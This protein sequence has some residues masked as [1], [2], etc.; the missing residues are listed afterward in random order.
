MRGAFGFA[1]GRTTP[2][3]TTWWFAPVGGFLAA[4]LLWLAGVPVTFS[5]FLP[6]ALLR[7]GF[8]VLI[9]V[10]VAYLAMFLFWLAVYP[11]HL[12]FASQ[13]GVRM[14]LRQRLGAQMPAFVLMGVIIFVLVIFTSV[15]SAW[16]T[17]RMVTNGKAITAENAN[18]ATAP[19]QPS[20][21]LLPPKERY[22]FKFDPTKGMYFDIQRDG[23]PLPEGH[24]ANPTF[25]LHNSSAVAAADVTVTWQAE[26][27]EYRKLV[28]TG[29]LAKYEV[30]FRDDF[31]LDLV[32]SAGHPVPNFRYFPNPNSEAKFSFV[33]RDTDLF[34]PTGIYPIL[35]LFIAAKMPEE[36]GARTE[37]FPITIKA[38]WN[39]PDGGEPK[40]FRI[41]IRGVNTKPSGLGEAP[42]VAGYLEF[43]IE[44]SPG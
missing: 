37:A 41:K 21:S 36:L 6:N 26:I 10:I 15:G 23:S 22:T 38:S 19:T 29:H 24:T 7:S 44:K 1:V 14:A 42:E 31:T 8:E 18:T 25:I 2:T 28:K 33:A 13:G 16:L 12:K 11:I 35:G 40:I 9:C 30:V 4:G 32:S 17:V 43:E 5:E 39:V 34:L 20:L 27:S 3:A